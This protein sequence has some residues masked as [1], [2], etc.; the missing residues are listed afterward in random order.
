M[1]KLSCYSIFAQSTNSFLRAACMGGFSLGCGLGW[2]APSVEILKT[3]SYYMDDFSTDVIASVF[4]VGAALGTLLVPL[5]IDRIGRKW[6]MMVLIPP[7]IGGWILLI[8]AGSL[9]LLFVVGRLLTGACGGM[10]CVL[11]PM[12]SAEISEKQIRGT[13]GVF[14]QLLLVLGILYAYC[15]GFTRNVVA[16]SSLCCIAPIVFGITMFFMPESPLFY[17]TKNKEEQARKSMRFFRGED[18]DIEPEMMVFK[19]QVERSKR[20]RLSF[21]AF[22]S[23][24][25]MKTLAVAYGLMFAQ[26][27]SGINAMIFYGLTILE[28]TGVGM[29]A[30][31]ELVIFGIVQ[32][33]AC[34][35]AALLI[36]QVNLNR[37]GRKL[38]MVI[39]EAVMCICLAALAGFFIVKDY[40]PDR[41]DQMDWLPLTSVCVYILAFCFGAGPIPW[42]YMGEIFPTRLKG[43]ASS[44]AAFFNWMLA[45]IVTISFPSAVDSLGSAA[46]LF[47]F[48]LICL[49]SVFFVIFCMVETKGKTFTEIQQEYGTLLPDLNDGPIE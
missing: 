27:F 13:T 21:A 41:V 16:I 17:L 43:A 28:S 12:Y 26:Q 15:T 31:V 30:L 4:P 42:A 38:L 1:N 8:C 39:S 47:F 29:D 19:E 22:T 49:L 48:A 46:V 33:I 32:V 2:S 14:F 23:T 20:Q 18:F 37:L 10:F 35:A 9:V 44:S 6:S 45:F 24:P 25:V 5:L 34:V 40:Y 7:F 36:D 11:V 3:D